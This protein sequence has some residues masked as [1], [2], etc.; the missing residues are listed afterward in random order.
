MRLERRNESMPTL[1]LN[2]PNTTFV[3]SAQPDNNLS[4]YPLMY[5]GTD[6]SFQYCISL[7]QIA[8][9][10]IPVTKVDS[11]LL[12]LAVIVKAVR[13]R[14]LSLSTELLLL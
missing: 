2:I 4:T 5:A 6:P 10:S 12:Q 9:P 11:A 8:L 3:S 7:M 13:L 14:A 1:T